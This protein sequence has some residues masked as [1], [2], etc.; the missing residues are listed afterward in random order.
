MRFGKLI[1]RVF[2]RFEF[3]KGRVFE[4]NRVQGALEFG[5]GQDNGPEHRARDGG[6]PKE[7]APRDHGQDA[8]RPSSVE[9]RAPISILKISFPRA[10]KSAF[11][12]GLEREFGNLYQGRFN[13]ILDY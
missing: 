6:V 13:N 2:R 7:D 11:S 3:V 8:A 1:L 10:G 5:N 4:E 12:G 9:V